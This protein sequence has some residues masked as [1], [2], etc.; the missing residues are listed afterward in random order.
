MRESGTKYRYNG[1][2]FVSMFNYAINLPSSLRIRQQPMH[3]NT[4]RGYR[5]QSSE[6]Q[7]LFVRPIS[8]LLSGMA[9]R[10]GSLPRITQLVW[11]KIRIIRRDTRCDCCVN[12][13]H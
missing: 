4:N 10:Y 6:H 8:C 5:E 2:F 3:V 9:R 1:E 7:H 12:L 11:P 13:R